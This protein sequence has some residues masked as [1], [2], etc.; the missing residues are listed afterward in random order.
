MCVKYTCANINDNLIINQ[1]K[2]LQIINSVNNLLS[3]TLTVSKSMNLMLYTIL[4]LF[5]TG[6]LSTYTVLTFWGVIEAT[7]IHRNFNNIIP[8]NYVEVLL[9]INNY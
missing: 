7:Y 9:C 2:N 8:I 1:Y 3:I 4:T 6:N 5:C